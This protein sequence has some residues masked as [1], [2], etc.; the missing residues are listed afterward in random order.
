MALDKKAARFL[1]QQVRQILLAEWNPIGEGV[2]DN[3]YDHYIGPLVT[4]LVQNRPAADLVEYLH[5]ITMNQI[6]L[7]SDK[8]RLSSVAQSLKSIRIP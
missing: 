5:G 7:T 4:M 6:G 1:Q 8:Q 2:P 3:E